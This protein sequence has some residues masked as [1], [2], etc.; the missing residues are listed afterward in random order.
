MSNKTN[1]QKNIRIGKLLQQARES[2]GYL[3]S[4]MVDATGLTKNHISAIERGVSKASVEMMLGYCKKL[5]MT[6]NE[7]LCIPDTK[8]T[9]HILPELKNMLYEMSP[10]QQRKVI[11]LIKLV[12]DM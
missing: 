12:K 6:P 4:D 11:N 1:K 5:N 9:N 8:D 3:Q 2:F 10:E 7:I